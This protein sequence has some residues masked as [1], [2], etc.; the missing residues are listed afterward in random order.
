MRPFD[1]KLLKILSTETERE[2]RLKNDPAEREKLQQLMTRSS[3]N[4][5]VLDPLKNPVTVTRILR[6]VENPAHFLPQVMLRYVVSGTGRVKVGSEEIILR[7]GDIFIPNQHARV[8]YAALGEEDI[9]LCFIMKPQFL[10]NVCIRMK[11][12]NILSDFLL[13]TLRADAGW[14]RY[15]H[16]TQL[17][18][19][20]FCNLMETMAFA[21]FPY[22]NDENIMLGSD[23]SPELTAQI[24]E[25]ILFTLVR[26]LSALEKDACLNFDEVIRRTVTSYIDTEYR[27]ASL[28]ELAEMV[29]QSESTLSRQIKSLFGV[30]FKEL[31]L[32][33]RFERAAVLLQQTNLPVGDVAIAVGYEN[34]SFFYRR[35]REVHG[36][37]PRDFR[38]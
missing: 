20:A 21:A 17:D 33:K 22:L 37:S 10:E 16:F 6:Y 23:P 35:F 31:L 9:H 29:N 5:R 1:A 2:T 15:L 14:N 13:E 34:T 36:R 3:G 24:M 28:Q 12:D 30:T 4:Q 11:K 7:A 26:S 27:T 18:D 8:S 25:V 38:K 19:L 32:N